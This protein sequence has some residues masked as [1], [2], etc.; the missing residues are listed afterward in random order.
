VRVLKCG[1]NLLTVEPQ[2]NPF[3]MLNV[4]VDFAAI[5]PYQL[6]HSAETLKSG[7]V[8]KIIV[9]GGHVSSVLEKLAEELPARMYETYGMTETASHIALRCFNG[10]EKS[11]YFT[12]LKGVDIRLDERGCL[13]INA[14]HLS[15]EELTTNDIIE[16]NGKNQF[17]WLGRADSVINSGG[18]KIFPEQ[19]EKKL[20]SL[21]H[22]RF[23]IS[24]EL[25]ELLG[26]KVVLV[27]ESDGSGEFSELKNTLQM[28]LTKYEVPKAIYYVPLFVASAANK[29]LRSETIK[30]IKH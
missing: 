23:F 12:A 19:V 1:F 5:T 3:Q 21:I 13:V 6:H 24:S 10:S 4:A 30:L 14:P 7:S 17:K 26:E 16:L 28:V 25:D 2:A 22:Q 20:E 18:V 8:K 15:P 29:V 9:G 11:D 27:I